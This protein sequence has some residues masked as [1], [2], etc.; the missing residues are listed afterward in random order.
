MAVFRLPDAE[1]HVLDMDGVIAPS[2]TSRPKL[3]WCVGWVRGDG[4]DVQLMLEM[5]TAKKHTINVL[6][7][8]LS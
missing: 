8:K 7:A 5:K 4:F 6:L 2:T 3:I 1:C